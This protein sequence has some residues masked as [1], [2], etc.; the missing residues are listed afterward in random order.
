MFAMCTGRPVKAH[1]LSALPFELFKHCVTNLNI[2]AHFANEQNTIESVFFK[3]LSEQLVF[4]KK[5]IYK[6]FKVGSR[7][8]LKK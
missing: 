5:L 7:Y 4:L 6:W 8:L 2:D 1:L 3:I